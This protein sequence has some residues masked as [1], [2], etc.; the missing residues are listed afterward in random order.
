MPSFFRGRSAS[1]SERYENVESQ[2]NEDTGG[3]TSFWTET[4]SGGVAP[5]TIS[6]DDHDESAAIEP[7]KSRS[8]KQRKPM[9]F[10]VDKEGGDVENEETPPPK[11]IETNDKVEAPSDLDVCCIQDGALGC[12]AFE[13]V[14]LCSKEE[15]AKKQY[16]QVSNS[17]NGKDNDDNSSY[18]DICPVKS[19]DESTIGTG[20]SC[21]HQVDKFRS[22]GAIRDKKEGNV[23]TYYLT[24]CKPAPTSEKGF[25]KDRLRLVLAAVTLL[26][27]VIISIIVGVTLSHQRRNVS[28]H[29]GPFLKCGD[30]ALREDTT[31]TY[32]ASARYVVFS[33]IKS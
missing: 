22:M 4:Y 9:S 13:N 19:A 14:V 28:N 30:V 21:S 20:G 11:C 6:V 1:K 5:V 17:T 32:T 16:T 31:G 10:F 15:D 12:L 2:T 26:L 7:K 24:F 29:I 33:S 8:W 18:P 27:I 3:I 23:L 25:L